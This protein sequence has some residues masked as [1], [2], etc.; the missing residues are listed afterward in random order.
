MDNFSSYFHNFESIDKTKK[1]ILFIAGAGMDHRLVRAI[2]LPDSEYNR[3]LIIDLPGHGLTQ[4][5]SQVITL[6]HTAS[7]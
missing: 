1:T 6:K 5:I 3:P 7:F 2:K 4:R